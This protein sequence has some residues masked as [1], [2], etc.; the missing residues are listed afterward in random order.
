MSN[1]LGPVVYYYNYHRYIGY[2]AVSKGRN[3]RVKVC[4]GT[5]LFAIPEKIVKRY[6]DRY[7]LK[8]NLEL[9]S[10]SKSNH[11]DFAPLFIDY[12]ER[13]NIEKFLERKHIKLSGIEYLT[14]DFVYML[15]KKKIVNYGF[16]IAEKGEFCARNRDSLTRM[17]KE[18]ALRYL[19]ARTATMAQVM[20]VPFSV[21]VG[22][23]KA[24]NYLGMNNIRLNRIVYNPALFAYDPDF[25]DAIIIHELAHCFAHG[26]GKDFYAIIQKYCPRYREYST[27]ISSGLFNREM[28]SKNEQYN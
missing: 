28:V 7:K 23:S 9:F 10:E 20:K 24:N 11:V 12:M 3:V 21:Q 14:D 25:S 6:I 13:L 26:H 1:S 8:K 22:L 2:L 19:S 17:Y 15:G 27:Y 18:K 16:K 5:L 4:Y